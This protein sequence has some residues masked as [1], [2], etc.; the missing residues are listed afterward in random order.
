MPDGAELVAPIL[1]PT[2]TL[3]LDPHD[4]SDFRRQAYKMLDDMLGYMES[5][6]T[7]PVWQVIP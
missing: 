3:S 6:R 7:F 5:I 1:G 2:T 4:W